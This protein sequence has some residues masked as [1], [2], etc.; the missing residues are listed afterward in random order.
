MSR[1][2]A[3]IKAAGIVTDRHDAQWVHYRRHPA[4]APE[5]DAI[6][7]AVLT[8]IKAREALSGASD[9]KRKNAA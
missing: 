1:H 7:D 6:L 4:L 9:A 8:A 2:M 5:L 3:V